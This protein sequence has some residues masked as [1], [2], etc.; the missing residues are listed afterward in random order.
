VNECLLQG[1]DDELTKIAKLTRLQKREAVQYAALGATLG[2]AVGSLA[3]IIMHGHPKPPDIPA[4][5]WVPASMLTG[6]IYGGI[7]P[8]LRHHI[9]LKNLKSMR[10]KK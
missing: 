8:I 6:A 5:R 2:P 10:K 4:K 9:H 7:I 3:H 1:F